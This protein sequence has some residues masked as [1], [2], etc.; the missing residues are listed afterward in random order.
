[1][2]WPKERIPSLQLASSITSFIRI[3]EFKGLMPC[4]H[5]LI[6]AGSL[7]S[8]HLSGHLWKI[9]FK[10]RL[11]FGFVYL[12]QRKADVGTDYQTFY[13]GAIPSTPVFESGLWKIEAAIY[14][15]SATASP[16]TN[17]NSSAP[18]SPT[19]IANKTSKHSSLIYHSKAIFSTQP[20][21]D[22]SPP[23][24]RISNWRIFWRHTGSST[25][26]TARH[27]VSLDYA[28]WL[29]LV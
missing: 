17:V 10:E 8:W 16:S 15:C 11:E 5:L 14:I 26:W 1:M 21:E 12:L 7:T 29:I 27:Y 24:C 4:C 13:V 9:F 3:L 28:P 20:G 2:Q 6:R 18:Y 25:V 19:S 22:S 23:P